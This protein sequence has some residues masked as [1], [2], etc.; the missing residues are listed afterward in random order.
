MGQCGCQNGNREL[1]NY[2]ERLK[3]VRLTGNRE[4]WI[5]FFAEAII[6]TANQAVETAQQRLDLRARNATK[7]AV[8][9]GRRHPPCK[10]TG[11]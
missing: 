7:S 8:W 10:S 1:G 5:D 11:H 6:T 3:N 9:A 4:A 2:Y